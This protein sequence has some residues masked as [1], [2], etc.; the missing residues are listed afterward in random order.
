MVPIALLLLMLS[1]SSSDRP[2]P[3]RVVYAGKP[4]SKRER[5]WVRFLS[6]HFAAV[7]TADYERFTESDA[8]DADVIVFDWPSAWYPEDGPR[9]RR[10]HADY[11]D[12]PKLP[13]T[14]P[15]PPSSSG[16]PGAMVADSLHLKLD[17]TCFAEG[18]A[19]HDLATSHDIFRTP[20]KVVPT[21]EGRKVP[22]CYKVDP[23]ARSRADDADV[24]GAGR[25]ASTPAP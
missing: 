18:D 25:R 15:A 24:E 7:C 22:A 12:P 13:R 1:D 11:P 10:Q 6:R 20:F 14:S 23:A 21:Y 5:D 16:S 19:A 2:L 3:V 8:R 17:A 4:G 9:I